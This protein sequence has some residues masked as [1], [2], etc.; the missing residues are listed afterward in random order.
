MKKSIPLL[1]ALVLLLTACGTPS[2]EVTPSSVPSEAQEVSAEPLEEYVET[3]DYYPPMSFTPESAWVAEPFGDCGYALMYMGPEES[4]A[5]RFKIYSYFVSRRSGDAKTIAETDMRSFECTTGGGR[6]EY[7]PG[8]SGDF[9][10]FNSLSGEASLD[11]DSGTL[12][13]RYTQFVP[14][15]SEAV[16]EL[17]R[18]SPRV[19]F[20][21]E[22]LG[23][24]FLYLPTKF[25]RITP[26]RLGKMM[27]NMPVYFD[28]LSWRPN[29]GD[30]AF[31]YEDGK[32]G[33]V[34]DNPEYIPNIRGL[35]IGDS[36][37]DI[38]A[39]IPNRQGVT[40]VRSGPFDPRLLSPGVET[41]INLYGGMGYFYL[42]KL[43]Y[44]ADGQ[45]EAVTIAAPSP[46]AVTYYLDGNLRITSVALSAPW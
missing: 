36:F 25:V 20:D 28:E 24:V 17:D 18:E 7:I 31:L 43:S 29:S 11:L 32:A 9:K 39:R 22:S 4:G 33:Y 34:T 23:E 5:R 46:Y 41:D 2:A 44:G 13:L 19:I 12:E 6:F 30:T 15:I 3:P 14:S 21:D 35:T 16:Y 37:A 1:L 42:A 38:V 45:P 27:Y 10:V 40:Q 8:S 26:D